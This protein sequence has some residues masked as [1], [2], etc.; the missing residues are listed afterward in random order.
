MKI[1][2][3]GTDN[4]SASSLYFMLR[5]GYE[6]CAV[7]THSKAQH[8]TRLQNIAKQNNIPFYI[9]DNINSDDSYNLIKEINPDI[10]FSIH[11]DRILHKRIID[12]ALKCAIN[13]HPSLLPKYR[14]MSPFQSVLK[15]NESQTGITIHY[16]AENVDEGDIIEQMVIPLEKNIYLSDLYIIMMQSYPVII[17][18]ALKKIISGKF[19]IIKQDGSK[20]ADCGKIKD[21]KYIK[22]LTFSKPE[23]NDNALSAGLEDIFAIEGTYE[24]IMNYKKLYANSI[25]LNDTN[26]YSSII[27][28][29]RYNDNLYIEK[30]NCCV[31]L[32]RYS[33]FYKLFY[34]TKDLNQVV[35]VMKY[36][37]HTL[38][39]PV[40]M[41]YI[42]KQKNILADKILNE[43]AFFYYG[44]VIRLQKK[45]STNDIENEIEKE[46]IYAD[47]CDIN[48][49]SEIHKSMFNKYIDRELSFIELR[50]LIENKSVFLYKNNGQILGCLIY[51]RRGKFYHLRNWFVNKK[52]SYNIKGIGKALLYK[53]Y[54]T[55]GEG[56]FIEVWS[57]KDNHIVTEIYKRYGFLED[58]LN[59]DIFI[60][61]P[62]KELIEPLIPLN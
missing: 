58:G 12:L 21:E 30:E 41:E 46:I 47:I 57:R 6:I 61:S 55:A 49:I 15:N 4:F 14:G 38:K 1:L 51:S 35:D 2:L 42:Y 23:Y 9:L 3:L 54:K 22:I 26:F 62:L 18:K 27:D 7:I 48:E 59:S 13:L 19:N 45:L 28:E 16:M 20:A 56:S 44:G 29:G 34:W 53:L 5:Y 39:Y 43:T 37:L 50:E 25:W 52:T 17:E 24:E 11:F 36:C 40:I 32:Y 33:T 10:I 60:Y 8:I 31:L